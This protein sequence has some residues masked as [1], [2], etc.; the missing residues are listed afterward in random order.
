MK[1]TSLRQLLVLRSSQPD[2]MQSC[3]PTER[4]TLSNQTNYP[5]AVLMIVDRLVRD[6]A[7]CLN[8]PGRRVDNPTSVQVEKP[9]R[10]DRS[11]IQATQTIEICTGKACQAKGAGLLLSHFKALAKQS[12]LEQSESDQP[13]IKIRTCS[14]LKHCGKAPVVRIDGKIIERY[15]IK[16]DDSKKSPGM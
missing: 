9:T 10:Q 1:P 7:Y 15:Q 4:L 11:L 13:L 12:K 8:P 3:S 16:N 6:S 14:C 5:P 2:S